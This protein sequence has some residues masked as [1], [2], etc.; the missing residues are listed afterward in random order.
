L[1]TIDGVLHEADVL[2]YG[3]GFTASHFL[4]PARVVGRDGVELHD[5]WQG[6]ARAYLGITLPG[7]P[8]L[9]LLYGPNTNIVVNGSITYF[10]ECEVHYVLGCVRALLDEGAKALE[11]RV[12]VHDA[13][14]ERIDAENLQMAWGVSTVNSWYKNAA[15]RTAQNWPFSLLEYWQRTRTP[16]LEDY[17]LLR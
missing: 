17:H 15:G 11:P 7:F 10:S 6:D 13:F 3:T 8:N 2:I 16:D 14:N 9:F 4:L 5:R 1:R 12:D